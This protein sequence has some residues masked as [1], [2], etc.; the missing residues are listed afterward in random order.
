[1]RQALERAPLVG[2]SVEMRA[3]GGEIRQ[4]ELDEP[5]P[6][7]LADLAAHLAEPGLAAFS[8]LGDGKVCWL[9]FGPGW[10]DLE[11][12]EHAALGV[13]EAVEVD[14]GVCVGEPESLED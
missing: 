2:M 13:G 11:L 7:A 10:G 9:L 6:K 8:A 3:V 14:A 4:P 5:A 12:V 1:M